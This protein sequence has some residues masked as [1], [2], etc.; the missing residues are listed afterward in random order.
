MALAENS[1]AL[2]SW[3][4]W[5]QWYCLRQKADRQHDELL[6]HTASPL[7]RVWCRLRHQI[8]PIYPPLPC[9]WSGNDSAWPGLAWPGPAR[10]GPARPI[11]KPHH[12]LHSLTPT[13]TGALWFPKRSWDQWTVLA[14]AVFRGAKRWS[15]HI[16]DSHRGKA[17]TLYFSG[18]WMKTRVVHYSRKTLL[19]LLSPSP[20][21]EALRWQA[22]NEWLDITES[23]PSQPLSDF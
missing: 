4:K 15:F 18:L 7:S 22:I 19:H 9:S 14:D 5:Q 16:G 6:S 1:S 3:L 11:V 8:C 23:R 2:H 12:S 10:S 21:A 17:V 13:T 20:P